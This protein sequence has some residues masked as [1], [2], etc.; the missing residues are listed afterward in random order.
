MFDEAVTGGASRYKAAA[1]IDVSE[2]T[3][4]RWRSGCGAVVEDQCPHA[5][6]GSQP[7]Q[8]THEEEQAILNACYRPEHQSLPPSQIVP[9]LAD[10]GVYLASES[11]F[12]R[13][14]KKHH[15]Q[16]HRGRMKPRRQVP[17]PT[18]LTATG[19]NQVWC[20]D[21]VRHEAPWKR[22]VMKEHC[23]WP[24]AAGQ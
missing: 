20:W 5:V 9:L 1:M 23:R 10:K 3:L 22:A 21:I 18:S 24:V 19:P 7:H 16:H 8:L 2:R 13:I 17:E 12:Y 14:L 11:S 15:L 4:K 6:Q